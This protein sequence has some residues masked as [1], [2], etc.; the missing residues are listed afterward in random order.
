MDAA[1]SAALG[2][3]DGDASGRANSASAAGAME[4]AGSCVCEFEPR[5]V[6]EDST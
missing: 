6:R 3:G 1:G 5:L 4:P 2:G